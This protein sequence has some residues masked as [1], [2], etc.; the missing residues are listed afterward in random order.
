VLDGCIAHVVARRGPARRND[1]YGAICRERAD[2]MVQLEVL[3]LRIRA[4]D[5]AAAGHKLCR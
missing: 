2:V 3:P 5:G 1:F 4:R